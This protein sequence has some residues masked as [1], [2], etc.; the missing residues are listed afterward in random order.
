MKELSKSKRL[1]SKFS[2]RIEREQNNVTQ[3]PQ[4]FVGRVGE[5]ITL[6][7]NVIVGHLEQERDT[8]DAC[9]NFACLQH[10]GG[11]GRI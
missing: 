3:M 7:L 6:D 11:N 10:Q 4:A 8:E 1:C 2:H 9:R 5:W